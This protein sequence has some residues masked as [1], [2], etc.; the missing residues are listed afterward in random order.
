MVA[1]QS[2]TV[3]RQTIRQIT[4]IKIVNLRLNELINI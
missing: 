4:E 1:V 3:K 2:A